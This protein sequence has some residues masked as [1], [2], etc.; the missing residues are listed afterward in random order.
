[1]GKPENSKD[2]FDMDETAI[3]LSALRRLL[4]MIGGDPEDM[5]E[6]LED[7]REAAPDLA[8]QIRVAAETGDLD[9]LRIAAH[10]LKSNARDFGAM[11]LALLCEE[12]EH[13]CRDGQV[14]DPAGIAAAIAA[15]EEAARTRLSTIDIRSVAT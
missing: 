2:V 13:A 11:R 5:A 12:L 8:G 10:T 14:G 7:Y 4:E 9:A 6:L 15:E 1:M 3:D